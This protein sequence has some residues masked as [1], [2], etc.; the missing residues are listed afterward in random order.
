MQLNLLNVFSMEA[1]KTNKYTMKFKL[2]GLG[3]LI[4][5]QQS[6]LTHF[7]DYLA[8]AVVNG[9]VELSY[10]LGRQTENNL[11]ILQSTIY[12][13]DGQW[14]TLYVERYGYH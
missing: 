5:V 14:H 12:V 4:L 6:D 11:H 2:S 10:N 1:Q 8:I 9:R 3:G 7:A 13:N